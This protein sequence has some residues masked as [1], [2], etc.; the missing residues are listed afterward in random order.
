LLL[1]RNEIDIEHM[2]HILEEEVLEE[3]KRLVRLEEGEEVARCVHTRRD[4]Y[5]S[6]AILKL[7]GQNNVVLGQNSSNETVCK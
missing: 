2:L 5:K 4:I 6:N 1:A 7:K 3:Q